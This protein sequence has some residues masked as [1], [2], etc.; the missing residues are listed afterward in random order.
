[1]SRK[2]STQPREAPEMP[3]ASPERNAYLLIMMTLRLRGSSIA[4]MRRDFNAATGKP[5][6]TPHFHRALQGKRTSRRIREFVNEYLGG[7]IL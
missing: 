3:P 7:S 6:S 4:Q 5:V 1:M 2:T